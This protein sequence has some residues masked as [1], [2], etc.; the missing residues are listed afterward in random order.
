[1]ADLVAAYRR[2][3]R[4]I[5]RMKAARPL[6]PTLH[7][8]PDCAS[9]ICPELGVCSDFNSAENPSAMVIFG[10]E[11]TVTVT[12]RK[13]IAE[14]FLCLLRSSA[15]AAMV[16]PKRWESETCGFRLMRGS[17]FTRA[18]TILALDLGM[19]AKAVKKFCS[20]VWQELDW[21]PR[22]NALADR[23]PCCCVAMAG[24]IWRPY[25][26]WQRA[27]PRNPGLVP[28]AKAPAQYGLR[29]LPMPAVTV[30]DSRPLPQPTLKTA[31]WM[32][33]A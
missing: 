22:S 29:Q 9:G 8:E 12:F 26:A 15:E 4:R 33:V 14:K 32:R 20:A 23:M 11:G 24:I 30:E 16:L 17:T 13:S 19:I 2:H 27:G 28:K 10:G 3:F 6:S 5:S 21:A 25:G 7:T 31:C 18:A 1:M